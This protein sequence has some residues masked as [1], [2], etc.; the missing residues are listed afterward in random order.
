MHD[1]GAGRR[2]GRAGPALVAGRQRRSIREATLG[3]LRPGLKDRLI[4][5]LAKPYFWSDQY[6]LKIQA[7]GV[8]RGHDEVR[9][10]DGTIADG[11]FVAPPRRGSRLLGALG[12]RSARALRQWR[13][14]LAAGVAWSDILPTA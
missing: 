12:V 1:G 9:V 8:L 3:L 13:A 5:R 14:R 11:E 6:D 10:V 7:Y 4:Q 2:G